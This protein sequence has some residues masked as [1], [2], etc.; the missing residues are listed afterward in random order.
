MEGGVMEQYVY[1]IISSLS[2]H[3]GAS[4][5]YLL[6]IIIPHPIKYTI[7]ILVQCE[8]LFLV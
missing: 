8:S 3:C 6:L 5:K 1:V 2:F 7:N 4:D